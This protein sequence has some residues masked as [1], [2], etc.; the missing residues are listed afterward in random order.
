LKAGLAGVIVPSKLYNVLAS[1][2]AC[3]TA[4]DRDCE[5]AHIVDAAGCG[6][7]VGP[8]DATALRARIVELAGDQN[9]RREMGERARL[10]ALDFDRPRQVAAYDQLLR[11]V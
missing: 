7:V 2:R 1:G 10:A 6:F 9:R 8:G 4:V 11:E 3:I 5:V